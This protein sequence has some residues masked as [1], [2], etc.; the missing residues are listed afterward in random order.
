M[1]SELT[2][3]APVVVTLPRFPEPTSAAVGLDFAVRRPNMNQVSKDTEPKRG[4]SLPCPRLV[5]A[6]GSLLDYWTDFGRL[7]T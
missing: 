6:A 3:F 1:I 2:A 7:I 5:A 4:S